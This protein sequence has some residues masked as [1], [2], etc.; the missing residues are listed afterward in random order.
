M[1]SG[2]VTTLGIISG[3]GY[4]G[5]IFTCSFR[6]LRERCA[7]FVTWWILTRHPGRH[8]ETVES[9]PHIRR[10]HLCRMIM[11]HHIRVQRTKKY[12][13]LGP[14][15][16]SVNSVSAT[17]TRKSRRPGRHPIHS[18]SLSWQ[19]PTTHFFGHPRK[20]KSNSFWI[21]CDEMRLDQ[22]KWDQMRWDKIRSYQIRSD[23]IRSDQLRWDEIRW[24]EINW[25]EIRSDQIR[26]DQMN[27][28]QIRSD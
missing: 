12:Q 2:P 26:S 18:S 23:Q 5:E 16:T 8:Q 20:G 15:D 11:R 25:D 14:A 13:S 22:I 1:F 28:D 21:A 27:W 10:T 9:S 24:D 6:R 17:T 7:I 19:S 4:S 3:C